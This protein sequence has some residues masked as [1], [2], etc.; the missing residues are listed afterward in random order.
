[1]LRSAVLGLALLIVAACSVGT[2]PPTTAPAP[3]GSVGALPTSMPTAFSTPTPAATGPGATGTS[4]ERLLGW[5][6]PVIANTCSQ[7]D[8]NAQMERALAAALCEPEDVIDD[9]DITIDRLMY[10][11]FDSD[12]RMIDLWAGYWEHLGPP[13]NG[14]C[15]AGPAT[16]LHE[17]DGVPVGRL[18]CGDWGETRNVA[19]WWYDD[20]LRVVMFLWIEG[21]YPELAGLVDAVSVQP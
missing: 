16:S 5:I 3:T 13:A 9:P 6:P 15:A 11:S 19:A 14:E 2:T 1:M 4:Y 20:R 10:L 12:E 18:V 8:A 7:D 17:V 21:G